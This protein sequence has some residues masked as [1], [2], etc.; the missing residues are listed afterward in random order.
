MGKNI[1]EIRFK[2][3]WKEEKEKAVE[4]LKEE[5][6]NNKPHGN[7]VGGFIGILVGLSLIAKKK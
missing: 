6:W 7:L 3:T 1:N 5:E 4:A 2:M